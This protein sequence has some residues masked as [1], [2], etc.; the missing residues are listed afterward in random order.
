MLILGADFNM[1]D[2]FLY[3]GLRLQLVEEIRS[4]GIN[5]ERI[6]NAIGK[7]LRHKFMDSSFVKFSYKD[8]AFP[9]G[10]GQTISQPYTVA[11]QTRLL[12]VSERQRI[13]E[14]GTGSGYQAAVLLEMG[15][16]VYT[17][18][19]QKKLFLRAQQVLTD[20][21]YQANFFYGDGFKGKPSYGPYDRILVTAGAEEV[22]ELLTRQLKVGGIMVVPVG[23]RLSQDMI[24]IIR[25]G[26]ENFERSAHG[27]FAFVPMLK[28]T[29]T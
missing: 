4:K 20:L 9:I 29:E 27:S 12:E 7:V 19:R 18:E 2:S 24:R 23:G 17:I 5:D 1:A 3:K 21:G 16:V 15:A 28:G 25:T 6:L 8:Q 11:F 26:E 14:I 10:E 13:L 22:P